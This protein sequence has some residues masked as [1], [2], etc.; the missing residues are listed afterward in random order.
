MANDVLVLYTMSVEGEG[1]EEVM[2]N[3]RSV[4]EQ[5]DGRHGGLQRMGKGNISKIG[6]MISHI[7]ESTAS[8][9]EMK[10]SLFQ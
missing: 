2:G 9:L 8:R 1:I 6:S 5:N 4:D 3:E 7:V 10:R